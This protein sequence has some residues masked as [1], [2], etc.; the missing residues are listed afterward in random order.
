MDDTT[1]RQSLIEEIPCS[2][3]VT[4]I[5][6]IISQALQQIRRRKP[7]D[8]ERLAQRILDIRW[9]PQEEE[10]RGFVGGWRPNGEIEPPDLVPDRFLV[11]QVERLERNRMHRR[12][13]EEGLK[14]TLELARVCRNFSSWQITA[15][16]THELGHACTNYEDI[17]RR[18]NPR[19]D[20][21]HADEW[22][23]E[24]CADWYAYRWGFGRV[25]R[26][27]IPDRNPMHHLRG[28]GTILQTDDRWYRISRNFVFHEVNPP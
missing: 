28:P 6:T 4:Q 11:G 20:G 9:L 3:R 22:S 16:I 17:E 21:F 23:L 19:F 5:R 2:I 7:G 26:K 14:G 10:D 24:L 1:I 25:I 13:Y 8:Y 15:L 18:N 27:A 12:Q